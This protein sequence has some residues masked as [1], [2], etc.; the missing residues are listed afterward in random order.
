MPN[1][2]NKQKQTK[3]MTK[4]NEK[5]NEEIKAMTQS[6][7][8]SYCRHL[9]NTGNLDSPNNPLTESERREWRSIFPRWVNGQLAGYTLA[10]FRAVATRRMFPMDGWQLPKVGGEAAT[11]DKRPAPMPTTKPTPVLTPTAIDT[12]APAPTASGKMDKAEII[13]S[14]L[15]GVSREDCIAICNEIIETRIPDG[16]PELKI[17]IKGETVRKIDVPTHAAF[18]RLL[19][20]LSAGEDT[21]CFG[22]AGTGKTELG[23][24]LAAA[25]D[26]NFYFTSKISA[27]H[28]F[29]G[30][31]D[32]GGKYHETPFFKAFTRG[33]LFL[34]D[35]MD[36]SNPNV[37]TRLNAA[38]ANRRCDFP[39]GI[40]EAHKDFVCLGAGNTSLGGA[41]R[42]Y[43]ARQQQDSALID[44]FLFV[45]V[46][47]DEKLER[48]I[49]SAYAGGKAAAERVQAVRRAVKRLKIRHTVSMRATI[50]LA[51]LLTVGD[52][53]AEAEAA[54]LW[55]SLDDATITKIEADIKAN[56]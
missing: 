3:T 52:T 56:A 9:F 25:M 8:R 20:Y 44:R 24:Q 14:I 50:K 41:S 38:L 47:Y 7:L 26:V 42:E 23:K 37:L 18:P 55:K 51:K 45:P 19:R 21:Y 35:E 32:G 10:D 40:F 4:L 13:A 31:V 36:A 27:E 30:F 28:H 48:S 49:A 16:L 39:N 34:F 11:A 53:K 33:G 5:T 15:N 2:R 22:P 12:T 54:A 29:Q 46:D 6:Q 1:G 17:I 43:N